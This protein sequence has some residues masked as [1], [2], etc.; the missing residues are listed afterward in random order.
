MLAAV[1]LAAALLVMPTRRRMPMFEATR[2]SRRRGWPPAVYAAAA[3]VV[4]VANLTAP[5]VVLAGVLAGATAHAHR[6]RT[7]RRRGQRAQGE[8]MASALQT[9]V[10]E[11]RVGAHPVGAFG[12]AAVE[13]SG[14]VAAALRAV[15]SRA[16]LGADV[17]SGLGE[18]GSVSAVP[19]YWSRVE[20]CWRL[21]ADH[22]L[23][24]AMLMR[25]AQSDI[26]ERQRFADRVDAG[27]AGARATAA[28][29]AGLPALGVLLGQL[30]GAQP[31]RFLLGDGGW[32]LVLGV[33][34][35]CAGLR[36]SEAIIDRLVP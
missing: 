35:V 32:L 25:A 19:S 28:I 13:S 21:A 18:I 14:D 20:V 16:R 5:A 30:I 24:V 1:L 12:A 3:A 6:R 29:L 7:R 23:P 27:L 9:L 2:R 11:L 33:V 36:W 15:A 31:V 34:L 10:G 26:V 17:G 8:A 4:G 22:G